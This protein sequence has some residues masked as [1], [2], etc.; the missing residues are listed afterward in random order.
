MRSLKKAPFLLMEST[1]SLVNW[2]EVNTQKRPGMHELS[3]L[4]AVACGSNSVQYFQWRK[5]RGGEEKFHG[6]VVDHRNGSNTR[7]FR[8][9]SALGERLERISD[10]VA[11]TC[12]RA[13]AAILFDWE[14]WWAVEDIQGPRKNMAY[15]DTV[16]SHFRPF[17]EL[18]IEVDF[19]NEEDSMRA[20]IWS[21]P[22]WPTSTG[23]A[24]RS[25]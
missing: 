24:M 10:A 19:I 15:V 25:G 7:V 1:P 6:A 23:K 17:W 20:M 16:L 2:K 18:G 13:R 4:Q 5:S 11:P 14:N 21:A 12:N 9:V 8:E 22:L 3:S